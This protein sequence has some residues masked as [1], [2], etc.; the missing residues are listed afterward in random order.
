MHFRYVFVLIL[1]AVLCSQA[2]AT[3]PKYD[4]LQP[5][6]PKADW[7]TP[8]PLT[9]VI[10]PDRMVPRASLDD[11]IGPVD[12]AGTT[13]YDEQ[14]YTTQG[15]QIA[16]DPFGFVHHVWTK[17]LGSDQAQRHIQYNVWSNDDGSFILPDASRPVGVTVDN[18]IRAGYVN[19]CVNRD[20]FAF[21]AFHQTAQGATAP[22]SVVGI[23]V[24]P[25]LGGFT[26]NEIPFPEDR[27]IIYPKI[28]ADITDHLHCTATHGLP[29][30]FGF[31][32]RGTAY[33]TDGFGDSTNW[34]QGF[35][36]M[37]STYWL[38]RDIAA[39]FHS[40]RIAT[41]WLFYDYRGDIGN[42]VYLRTSDDGGVTW[43]DPINI[44]N[45]TP[46][47]TNCV[48]SGGDVVTCNMDTLRPAYDVTV[49]FDQNDVIHV[50]FT[51]RGVFY[52][53]ETGEVGPWI[54]NDC[55][56]MLWHWDEQNQEFNIVADH[57]YGTLNYNYGLAQVICQRPNLAVDTTNNFLYCSYQLYDTNQYSEAGYLQSDAWVTVS[58]DGGRTWA[59]STNVTNTNGGQNAIAGS[60]RSERDISV[61]QFVTNGTLHM[62]YQL[63]LDAGTGINSTSEGSITLNPIM[64]QRIPVNQIPTRPY[65]NPYRA[66]RYDSTGYP[67]D[68]DTTLAVNDYPRLAPGEFALYQNYPNPF[69]PGTSIQFDLAADMRAN[70]RV[71][72]VLGREVALLYNNA[73]L[74]AGTH[75]VE[76]DASHLA[77]GVYFCRLE[78][79]NRTQTRKMI[80][81]R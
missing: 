50:V 6:P 37:D 81:M 32:A 5:P 35:L 53:D 19:V 24:S 29:N 30:N 73:L 64:Y 16:V 67:F 72:D 57:Y 62:Q 45:F 28:V 14:Q 4:R 58:M 40:N 41:V 44:T 2:V 12:T 49:A 11:P 8:S 39:S 56:S 34:G 54:H 15:K 52:W 75:I 26:I 48:S 69:N 76:F 65:L 74:T 63:D 22:H 66:L 78:T 18:A 46:I 47:D 60:C 42:N 33:Y 21:P 68:L 23:D 51:T 1:T 59:L 77:S 36:P 10:N 80:L 70:L 17:S 27:R 25:G 61:A 79:A 13:W 7:V 3:R 38:T 31:Y 20:G 9:P 71:F 43:N 55:A